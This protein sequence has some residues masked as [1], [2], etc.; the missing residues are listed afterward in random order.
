MNNTLIEKIR[1]QFQTA[2]R[3]LVVSH[4]RPDGDAIGSMLGLGLSLQAANKEVQMVLSDG[5][6]S[7][8]RHLIGSDQVRYRPEGEFDL[9]SVVDC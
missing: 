6:P 1:H 2:Q 7:S 3:I 4:I 5:V 9:V 8:F